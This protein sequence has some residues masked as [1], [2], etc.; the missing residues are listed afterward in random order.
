MSATLPRE[1]SRPEGGVRRLAKRARGAGGRPVAGELVVLFAVGALSVITLTAGPFALGSF[2]YGD[3]LGS[4][5]FF[6]DNLDSLNRFGVPAWWS[7]QIG[8]GMPTYSYG[9]LGIVNAGKPVFVAFGFAAWLLGRLGIELPFVFPLYLVYFGALIPLMFLLGV[10]LVARQ[11]FRSR[12][13]VLY[14]VVVAAF[15]PGFLVGVSDPG[16]TENAAYALYFAAAYLHFVLRPSGRSLAILGFSVLPITICMSHTVLTTAAPMLPLLVLAS[17]LTSAWVRAALRRIRPMHLLAV[18]VLAF[19]TALPN[20][21]AYLQQKDELIR[22]GVGGLDYSFEELKAGNPLEFLLASV[23]AAGFQ[24]DRYFQEPDGPPAALRAQPLRWHE[25]AGAVYLG[26]LAIPLAALGLVLG[27]RPIRVPLFGMLVIVSTVLTL[28]AYSP[29]MAPLLILLPP[30]RSWNHMNDL[31]YPG[32]G[33][34]LLVFAAALGLEAAE[35]RPGALRALVWLFAGSSVA[36]LALELRWADSL[37]QSMIG[38]HGVLVASVAVVLLWARRSA[39]RRR[40]RVLTA[41]VLALTLIDVATFA[42]WNARM[43]VRGTAQEFDA[44]L[45]KR[46]GKSDDGT[47]IATNLALR[48]TDAMMRGGRLEDLPRLAV[49]CSAY[50]YAGALGPGDLAR[51]IGDPPAQRALPFPSEVENVP[52]LQSFLHAVPPQACHAKLQASGTYVTARV[53]VSADQ[54]ALLFVRDARA[55]GWTA[56][57]GGA[58]VEI[59]PALGGFKAIAIPAGD[60]DVRLRFAPRWIGST[61][62][63]AY[64][65][66]G[67]AA[68]AL[69]RWPARPGASVHEP[70]ATA[71]GPFYPPSGD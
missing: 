39:P 25:D 2:L 17:A 30:L 10:W 69:W 47:H 34:L 27:R 24:W 41:S 68:L 58:P 62:L 49:F 44:F 71:T 35:R 33:F 46:V 60:S 26:V 23:P 37:H 57:V 38:L 40:A 45:G 53:R 16:T 22:V 8:F 55:R 43:S 70:R 48:R 63:V 13:A 20:L 12:S 1:A 7:P 11:L 29:L 3:T 50:V 51:A 14:S 31:L 32:G 18:S 28:F 64:L 5:S 59:L 56:T 19:G 21:I 66:L 61:L 9:L 6:Y 36:A 65:I 15:S 42:F 67:L 54:P 52:S 4:Y